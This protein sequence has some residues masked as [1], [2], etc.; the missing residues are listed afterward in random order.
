MINWE[1]AYS[2]NGSFDRSVTFNTGLEKASEHYTKALEYYRVAETR[3]IAAGEYDHLTNVYYNMGWSHL[4][5]G[6]KEEACADFDR[7]LQARGKYA[8]QSGGA[9]AGL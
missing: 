5:L 1:K 9:T 3:E 4:A 8:A 2:R 7:T 6:A